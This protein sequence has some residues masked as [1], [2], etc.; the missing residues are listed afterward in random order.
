MEPLPPPEPL[1][2][3]ALPDPLQPTRADA[4]KQKM[5]AVMRRI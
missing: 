4:N 3:P 1:L 5:V 2:L